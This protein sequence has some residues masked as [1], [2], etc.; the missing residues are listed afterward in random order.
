ME[1]NKREY[2]T[3]LEKLYSIIENSNDVG[4]KLPQD[5]IK[6]IEEL[7]EDIIMSH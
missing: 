5:V 7:E 1:T 2:M 4:I 6:Q 3:K